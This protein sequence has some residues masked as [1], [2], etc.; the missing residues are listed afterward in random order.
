MRKSWL[1]RRL[2]FGLLLGL[3]T[4]GLVVLVVSVAFFQRGASS[5]VIRYTL[6]SEGERF[7]S[8]IHV[9]GFG[10]E[11]RLLSGPRLWEE[12]NL[13]R[14]WESDKR[15]SLP[16]FKRGDSSAIGALQGWGLLRR[17]AQ[18]DGIVMGDVSLDRAYGW[19][20]LA[21][22]YEVLPVPG[23]GIV[24][25]DGI[26]GG[27]P[28]SKAD[29]SVSVRDFRCMPLRPIWRGVVTNT[30]VYTGLWLLP[31]V[32]VPRLRLK[33][34]VR[35]GWCGWCGYDLLGEVGG[36]C[37]ECGWGRHGM[38]VNVTRARARGS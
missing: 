8:V 14:P 22:W 26:K 17:F 21:A 10:Y 12:V 16:Q 32:V 37:P 24:R 36:G 30:A 29:G 4:N 18:P 1:F 20:A 13:G 7:V 27:L 2:G 25:V 9:L 5:E 6:P 34:R 31:L 38:V 11:H 33:R 23:D 15:Q 19:P 28:L 3:L 35:K